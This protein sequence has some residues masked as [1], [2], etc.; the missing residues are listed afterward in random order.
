MGRYRP[1][2]TRPRSGSTL[3]NRLHPVVDGTRTV[4]E[5][6][7]KLTDF[8]ADAVM[9]GLRTPGDQG[10]IAEGDQSAMQ[11]TRPVRCGRCFQRCG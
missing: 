9:A 7:A 3:L 5:I 4:T 2:T 11:P 8:D 1:G 10:L 6:V